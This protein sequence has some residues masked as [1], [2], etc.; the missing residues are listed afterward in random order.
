MSTTRFVT[1]ALCM[2]LAACGSDVKE[3]LGL[4]HK[5]PDEFDVYARP[6]LTIPPEFNLRPPGQGPEYMSGQPADIAAHNK[7]LGAGTSVSAP[8]SAAASTLPS[9]SAPANAFSPPAAAT[10]TPPAVNALTSA[11]TGPAP[12]AVPAV[13]VNALP[14][15]GDSRFL[16]DAGVTKP[17]GSIRETIEKDKTKDD[18]ILTPSGPYLLTGKST[19]DPVVDPAKEAQRL[20]QDKDQNK[21]P[22]TGETPV[23]A[24]EKGIWGDIF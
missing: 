2:M 12:T 5:A 1:I 8:A 7:V 22:T 13:S 14:T 23:I 19:D 20:K 17:D 6:P 16:S 3:T 10:S 4:N 24:P 15:T 11:S 18:S 21:P 9:A